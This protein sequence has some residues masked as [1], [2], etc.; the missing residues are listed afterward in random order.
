MG[1]M[2]KRGLAKMLKGGVIMDVI[3]VEQAKIA[4]AAGAVAVMALERKFRAAGARSRGRDGGSQAGGQPGEGPRWAVET[5]GRDGPGRRPAR[6]AAARRDRASVWAA[7]RFRQVE[8]DL[9][10]N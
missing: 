5:G 4:E 7:A 10:L 1:D 3:D 9:R 6:A 8:T 2:E